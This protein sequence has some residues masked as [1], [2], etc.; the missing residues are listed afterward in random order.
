M[1]SLTRAYE[2]LKKPVITEKGSDDTATR[3]AYHFRVPVDANKV[4]I[5][6]AVEK[7]FKVKVR[8]VNTLR[9]TP[10]ARRRGWVA[11][12]TPEWKKAMVVLAEG[13]AIDLL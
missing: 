1:T 6:Q 7:L 4:E 3:N 11:G 12:Q 10:K 8:K 13:N 9:V 5:R 2:I